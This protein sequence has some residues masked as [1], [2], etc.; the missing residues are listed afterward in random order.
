MAHFYGKVLGGRGEA[1]RL[2]H[3]SSGLQVLAAS[4]QGA[5][6]V[7]LYV[8][9]DG[10]DCARVCLTTHQGAGTHRELYDGPVSGAPALTA[11]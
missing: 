2:G 1:S 7:S 11:S 3:K 8:N 6:F 4:W 9:D 10:V 5:V